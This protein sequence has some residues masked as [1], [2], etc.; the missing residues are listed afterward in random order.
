M[1]KIQRKEL[2]Q[3]ENEI[4]K[5]QGAREAIKAINP[6][7]FSAEIRQQL[8]LAQSE[9]NRA[10]ELAQ[11]DAEKAFHV[12]ESYGEKVEASRLRVE[13]ILGR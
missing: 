2:R 13:A 8:A 12:V 6:Y 9:Q 11:I 10:F 1:D 5:G 7:D 4:R 3:A